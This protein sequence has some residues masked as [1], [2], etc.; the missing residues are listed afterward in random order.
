MLRLVSVDKGTSS[1]IFT[2]FLYAFGKLIPVLSMLE[3]TKYLDT[4]EAEN[5]SCDPL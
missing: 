2:L 1:L 4:T 5:E 3:Y